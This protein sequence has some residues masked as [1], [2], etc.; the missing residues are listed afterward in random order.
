MEVNTPNVLLSNATHGKITSRNI[1]IGCSR[2]CRA[3]TS[4]KLHP[5]DADMDVS[6]NNAV[7]TWWG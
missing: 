6:V 5:H 7:Q 4:T 1:L 2:L 3:L